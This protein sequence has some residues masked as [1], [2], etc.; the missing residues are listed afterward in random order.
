MPTQSKWL[1]DE[2]YGVTSIAKDEHKED[3]CDATPEF[4]DA[5]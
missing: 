2:E 4:C 3:Q 1:W 5:M